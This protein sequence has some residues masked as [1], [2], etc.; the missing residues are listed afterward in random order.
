MFI[1]YK[2]KKTIVIIFDILQIYDKD[3]NNIM[4]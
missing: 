1:Y 2:V 3:Y 4:I